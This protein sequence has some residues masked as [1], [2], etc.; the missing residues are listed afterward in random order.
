MLQRDYIK[1]LLHSLSKVLKW[2]SQSSAIPHSHAPEILIISN[3]LFNF[4]LR[5]FCPQKYCLSEMYWVILA[6]WLRIK[7]NFLTLQQLGLGFEVVYLTSSEP[8]KILVNLSCPTPNQS[9]YSCS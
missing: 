1:E 4:S 5:N 2:L 7:T 6:K 9:S 3:V 8:E